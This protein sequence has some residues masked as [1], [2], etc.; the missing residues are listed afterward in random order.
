MSY[1]FFPEQGGVS[2]GESF[3]EMCQCVPLKSILSAALYFSRDKQMESCRGSRSGMMCGASME[4]LG[5]ESP[6]LYVEDSRAKIFPPLAAPTEMESEVGKADCGGKWR[7]SFAKLSPNMSSWKTPQLSLFE[8]SEEFSEIWPRWGLMLDGECF[9]QPM[10]EHDTSVSGYG[11]SEIVGTPIR[12][13][14]SR[15][16]DFGE[17]RV[18]NPYELC[19]QNGG[20]PKPEWV[21]NL[22]GWPTGWTDLRPLEMDKFQR[23]CSLHGAN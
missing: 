12:T 13:P 18:P 17:G 23:W 11:F 4:G 7:V 14:R 2:S 16:E 20:L 15:S 22:M 21:E 5:A 9:P 8:D 1:T 19:K 6:T 3:Q 10:L